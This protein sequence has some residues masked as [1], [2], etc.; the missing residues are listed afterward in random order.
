MAEEVQ[1]SAARI[2]ANANSEIASAHR[3]DADEGPYL[4]PT[5]VTLKLEDSWDPLFAAL[6]DWLRALDETGV[7]DWMC[8]N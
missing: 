2:L 1:R 7:A 6:R 5:E 3:V 8:V 4:V